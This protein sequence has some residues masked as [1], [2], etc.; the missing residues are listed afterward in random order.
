MKPAT[1]IVVAGI[2]AAI[3]LAAL[4]WIIWINR[5]SDRTSA[6]LI[7]AI[8]APL[9]VAAA[10]LATDILSPLPSV[11][12]EI[13]V[14]ILRDYQSR[15]VPVYQPLALA[16]SWSGNEMPALFTTYWA[17]LAKNSPPAS[18]K[19]GKAISVADNSTIV[20]QG[21]FFLDLF[22]ASF[23]TWLANRYGLHWRV[24]RRWF[25]GISGGGGSLSPAPD[26]EQH[27]T[28]LTAQE[29]AR[30]ISGN[31]LLRDPHPIAL[32]AVSLPSGSKVTVDR[33]GN[34]HHIRIASSRL[35]LAITF[36]LVG[37]GLLGATEL[38][39][40]LKSRFPDGP[41]WSDHIQVN[42]DCSFSYLY[43][44]SPAT[45]QQR[46]WSRT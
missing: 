13:P 15:L 37:G 31:A 11:T 45:T 32:S 40:K 46:E 27:P 3:T 42:F 2:F 14:L 38:A 21:G 22:E 9:L 8:L 10:L 17:W 44:W 6:I 4:F 30:R 7:K 35:E 12:A 19:S 25:Q 41:I 43:R 1:Q 18:D 39:E 24:Q 34:R 29:V 5:D 23:W 33:I 26:A 36:E 16:G 20:E 28:I